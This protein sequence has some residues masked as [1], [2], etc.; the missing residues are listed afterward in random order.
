MKIWTYT[1]RSRSVV[2]FCLLVIAATAH[3]ASLNDTGV[4]TCRN[5]ATGV[6]E[7]CALGTHGAQDGAVGRD[8]AA[9]TVGS[10]LT[11]VGAGGAGFDFTKI[12]NA[13]ADLAAT[14]ALGTATGDWACTRDNVTGLTWDVL[15]QST[16]GNV[17]RRADWAFTWYEPNNAINGGG[18]GTPSTAGGCQ[19]GSRCDTNK[20]VVDVNALTT[21]LCGQRDWRLPTADEL[22]TLVSF[23]GV[24]PKIDG[25]YFPNTS[26]NPY[27]TSTPSA[28]V[29]TWAWSVSMSDGSASRSA[30]KQTPLRIRLVRS[31]I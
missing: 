28:S 18:V 25:S 20:Y 1:T 22:M 3:A 23:G 11:K 31:G 10:G 19:V 27:W 9:T 2:V 30:Q 17:L 21:A 6:D 8:R 5:H 15:P 4:T 14:I 16:A 24:T 26:G 29:T 12:S 13:G 7:A